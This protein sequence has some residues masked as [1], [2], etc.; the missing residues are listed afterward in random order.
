MANSIGGRNKGNLI[1]GN[2]IGIVIEDKRVPIVPK[3]KVLNNFI[4]TD[5]TGN[6][7]LGNET[8]ILIKSGNENWIGGFEKSDGNVISGNTNFGI[9]I[10]GA[11]ET[12]ITGN[13]IGT[14]KFGK[15]AIPNGC[16]VKLEGDPEKIDCFN[17]SFFENL[18]SGNTGNGIEINNAEFNSVTGNLIGT[19]KDGVSPLPNGGHGIREGSLAK[20]NCIGGTE[21]DQQNTLKFNGQGKFQPVIITTTVTD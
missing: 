2:E 10:R 11:Q 19:Q 9:E 14:N 13:K 20:N 12:M 8:G 5:I 16:G 3:N 15:T 4:G 1:S 18:I 6:F 21:I 7:E 17:N